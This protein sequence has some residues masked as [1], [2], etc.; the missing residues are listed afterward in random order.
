VRMLSK[1][2]QFQLTIFISFDRSDYWHLPLEYF[3]LT[4]NWIPNNVMIHFH[5]HQLAY[6]WLHHLAGWCCGKQQ[7]W[8]VE[9]IGR[10]IWASYIF[11]YLLCNSKYKTASHNLSTRRRINIGIN[12]IISILFNI[13][14]IFAHHSWIICVVHH[15]VMA[16]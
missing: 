11:N 13:T 2:R 14:Y 6:K 3:L 15:N 12:I 9:T 1:S 8:S 16:G 4:N 5:Y 10:T 7:T